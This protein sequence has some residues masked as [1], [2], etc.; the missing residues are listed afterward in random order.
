MRPIPPALRG[1]LEQDPRMKRCAVA[2]KGFGACEGRIEW[3][4]SW[5]YAGQQINEDWAIIGVCHKHHAAKNGNPKLNNEVKRVSLRLAT[6][7]D[8]AMYPKKPWGRLKKI[9]SV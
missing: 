4:H 7:D 1:L 3:D 9:L 5:V 2:G 8:L 6:D